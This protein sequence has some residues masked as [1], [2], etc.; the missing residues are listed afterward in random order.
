[1]EQARICRS[2]DLVAPPG[3][4]GECEAMNTS[5]RVRH[6]TRGF[7]FVEL[8]VAIIIA[9][10]VF[11]VMVPMFVGAIKANSIDKVRLQAV[12]VAQDRVEKIRQLDYD[13]ITSQN[14]AS[15]ANT[16]QWKYAPAFGPE[17]KSDKGRVYGVSYAVE[18]V[19]DASSHTLYKRVSVTV[20]WT[21]PPARAPNSFE[22][23]PSTIDA[24]TG[25]KAFWGVTLRTFIYKQYAG[26]QIVDLFMTPDTSTGVLD[27]DPLPFGAGELTIQAVL[28]PQDVDAAKYVLFKGYGASTVPV[29]DEKVTTRTFGSP[30]RFGVTWKPETNGSKDGLYRFEATAYSTSGLPGNSYSEVFRLETGRPPAPPG[31]TAAAGNMVV[32]LNWASAAA[33]VVGYEVFRQIGSGAFSSLGVV[34][35]PTFLDNNLENGTTYNYYV[36]ASDAGGPGPPSTVATAVPF[37][38][39]DTA[40]RTS[41]PVPFVISVATVEKALLTWPDVADVVVP[42][43]LTSGIDHY[44][45]YRDSDPNPYSVPSPKIPGATVS[46]S[47]DI[48]VGHIYAVSSVDFDL[49]ESPKSVAVPVPYKAPANYTLVITSNK[50]ADYTVRNSANAVVATANNKTSYTFTLPAGSYQ[51]T[52]KKGNTT[53]GPVPVVLDRNGVTHNFLGL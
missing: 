48:T 20:D 38:P 50:Q 13:L 35:T 51:V 36:V 42:G 6:A 49:N 24:V 19:S 22:K 25:K 29:L 16:P 33:D 5:V 46:W 27:W 41:P 17:W 44:L 53:Y 1:V 2:A 52:A 32:S 7:S 39:A 15:S 45:V 8:L 34:T 12:N 18:E 21:A 10:I 28:S 47:Q 14:L 23:A 4:G 40:D 43:Q 31:L 3:R 11:A 26:P 30:L 9:G 37:A